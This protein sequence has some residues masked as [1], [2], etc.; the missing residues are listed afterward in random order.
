MFGPGRG[1]RA[2]PGSLGG[3]AGGFLNN[4]G[5]EPEEEGVAAMST[6]GTTGEGATCGWITGLF[7][8]LPAGAALAGRETEGN[9]ARAASLSAS[10]SASAQLSCCPNDL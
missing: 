2:T 5:S 3:G 10:L 6:V 8:L 4:L 9:S 1:V 7:V